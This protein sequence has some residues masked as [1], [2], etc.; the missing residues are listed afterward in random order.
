MFWSSWTDETGSARTGMCL[1]S[2][3][4]G[5][6]KV[7]E[8]VRSADGQREKLY[9]TLGLPGR[10]SGWG[11]SSSS[12]RGHWEGRICSWPA[13]RRTS[14]YPS[15]PILG[16]GWDLWLLLTST[17]QTV[18][19]L[20]VT[21][22]WWRVSDQYPGTLTPRPVSHTL[23]MAAYMGTCTALCLHWQLLHSNTCF[24]SGF[25]LRALHAWFL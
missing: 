2:L 4:C 10:R 15:L 20:H 14:N 11:A 8:V 5:L 9:L 7:G 25:G 22:N 23:F 19:R 18:S 17:S 6:D 12:G 24:A 1:P 3:Y 16:S 21:W 13:L